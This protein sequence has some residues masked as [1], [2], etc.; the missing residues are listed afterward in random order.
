MVLSFPELCD[1]MIYAQGVVDRTDL[2][3]EI[4]SVRSQI[5]HGL[6]IR[7]SVDQHF[8]TDS[9]DSWVVHV[10]GSTS[11]NELVP[12][13]RAEHAH[14]DGN[15]AMY[16]LTTTS[17][18]L[19]S[20]DDVQQTIK[21]LGGEIG[22]I[23][24][25]ENGLARVLRGASLERDRELLNPDEELYKEIL[26]LESLRQD[27]GQTIRGFKNPEPY[28]LLTVAKDEAY[29][30]E[31]A[32]APYGEMVVVLEKPTVDRIWLDG[33]RNYAIVRRERYWGSGKPLQTVFV[34]SDFE[35]VDNLWL[36][37][38][39][40][41]D[42]YSHP[43]TRDLSP[44]EVVVRAVL[45]VQHLSLALPA[46]IFQ[47]NLDAIVGVM[48]VERDGNLVKLQP[49]EGRTMGE[50]LDAA[51]LHEDVAPDLRLS[52]YTIILLNVG[53]VAAF[54]LYRYRRRSRSTEDPL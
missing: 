33:S 6:H 46:L 38:S 53:A 16:H 13:W 54:L 27:I 48:D 23:L 36:P 29:V 24:H 4:A 44:S 43:D 34:N 49:L 41:I 50:F 52:H 10:G 45:T 2:V 32:G 47:P 25:S 40:T 22:Y 42:Y 17:K 7:Y 30:I 1:S 18:S 9:V 5:T 12:F 14:A 37:K 28:D 20:E 19:S 15:R 21:V 39:S 31:S 11:G 51:K 8:V 3:R 35:R 26:G